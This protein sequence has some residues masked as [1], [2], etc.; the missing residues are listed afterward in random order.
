MFELWGAL[1]SKLPADDAVVAA[2][3]PALG[4]TL[5][6]AG[7][8]RASLAPHTLPAYGKLGATLA[9]AR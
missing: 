2:V 9:W 3:D 1:W 5:S 6:A 4:L 8:D 7:W